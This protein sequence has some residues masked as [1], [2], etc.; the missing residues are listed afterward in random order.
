MKASSCCFCRDNSA[1][2]KVTA[3]ES[4]ALESGKHKITVCDDI[5][6]DLQGCP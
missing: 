6:T 2:S 3:G 5:E 4:F 1:Q